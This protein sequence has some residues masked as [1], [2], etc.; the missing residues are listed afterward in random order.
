MKGIALLFLAAA[1]TS[2]QALRLPTD[3]AQ[4]EYLNKTLRD[5]PAKLKLREDKP[6]DV[7][8]LSLDE[9][10]VRYKDAGGGEHSVPLDAVREI[11]YLAPE[12]PRWAGARDGGLIGLA[13]AGVTGAIVG[14]SLGDD[15]P[16]VILGFSAVDKAIFLGAAAGLVGMIGGGLFGA[17]SG[18]HDSLVPTQRQPGVPAADN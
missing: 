1:C 2:T 9:T 4:L 17:L 18:H 7:F 8:S 12:H 10:T 11:N 6:F 15:R 13:L 16:D 5:Q 3:E 14:L